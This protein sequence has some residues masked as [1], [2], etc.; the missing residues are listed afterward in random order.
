MMQVFQTV[1]ILLGIPIITGMLFNWKFPKITAI[2]TKPIRIFSIIAFTAMLV[3][4]FIAN[5]EYFW[6]HIKYI[7]ILVFFHNAFAFLTGYSIASVFRLNSPDKRAVTIETGIQNSAL[8]LA[9][10]FNPKIFPPELAI[11]GMAF[12]AAWWGIW[13]ILAGLSLAGFWSNIPFKTKLQK[14][15]N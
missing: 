5:Y 11:G 8:G 7:L 9:L 14:N 6:A 13:H 2:I 4:A 12:I 1:F 10:L 15:I 3:L